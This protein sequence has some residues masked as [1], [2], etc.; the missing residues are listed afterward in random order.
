LLD[1]L[2]LSAGG[3]VKEKQK[4][5]ERRQNYGDRH[6]EL[7][8]STSRVAGFDRRK[9]HSTHSIV[10]SFERRRGIGAIC[11]FVFRMEEEYQTPF[12]QSASTRYVL[13]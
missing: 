5:K 7:S 6:N 9:T 4:E 10:E 3:L 1:R 12:S 8:T 11:G 13:L 2:S